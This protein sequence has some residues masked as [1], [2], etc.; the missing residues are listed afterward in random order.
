MG[1]QLACITLAMFAILSEAAGE[2]IDLKITAE[3]VP[4]VGWEVRCS[5]S[6]LPN[7]TLQSVRLQRNG[8]QFMIYRPEIHGTA[9]AEVFPAADV[10]LEVQCALTAE[11]GRRGDCLLSVQ[12]RLPPPTELQFSCEVS[13]ERPTFVIE[14]KD[15]TLKT[16]VPPS[17]AK[18]ERET[19]D[20]TPDRVMLNCSSTG[21]PAPILQWT[22]G[23]DK[24]QADFSGRLWNGTSKLW[25]VWSSLAYTRWQ[26]P[27]TVTCSPEVLYHHTVVRG[28][29]VAYSGSN[30]LGAANI[31]VGILT[32][33]TL[34]R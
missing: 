13:G 12:P 20:S 21:L 15:Y 18:L 7:D 1:D 4:Q 29:P 27:S 23:E 31:L 34:R 2:A 26:R 19:Y 28:T 32:V 17:V 16:L 3:R 33:V 8:Q 5:W 10:V 22:V 9:R 14:R 25:H 11:L 24:V 30:S 6:M